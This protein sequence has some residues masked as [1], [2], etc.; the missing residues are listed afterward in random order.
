MSKPWENDSCEQVRAY[1]EYYTVPQVA[2]L[3]CGVP[4]DKIE[5]LLDEC[6]PIGKEN[7]YNKNVLKHPLIPCL[8][9]RCRAI[10]DA[11]NNSRLKVGRDG[12]DSFY[13]EGQSVAY[14]RRTLKRC[15][16]KEWIAKE[17]P[18][19]KPAFLFDDIERSTH[20]AIN[21]DT[22]RALQADRDALKTRLDNGLEKYKILKQERDAIELELKSV[23]EQADKMNKP[24]ERSETTYLNIIGSLLDLMLSKSPAGKPHSIFE[25]QSAIISALLAYYK[26]TPGISQRTLEEKFAAAKRSLSS[27]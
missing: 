4:A 3:W 10:Y 24:S 13:I 2:M 17:F 12:G 11:I 16:L 18:N 20:T 14:S 9:P 23:R 1:Y 15:D 5:E 22:F 25:N 6:E 8:E 7:E 19:D 21:A 26:N 27:N